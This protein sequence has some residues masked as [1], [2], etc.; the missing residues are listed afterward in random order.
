MHAEQSSKVAGSR[1]GIGRE[2]MQSLDVWRAGPI[3]GPAR[4]LPWRPAHW[5]SKG[6]DSTLAASPVRTAGDGP[7][8]VDDLPTLHSRSA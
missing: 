4:E 6:W 8:D 1:G 2:I 7:N 5:R 3:R